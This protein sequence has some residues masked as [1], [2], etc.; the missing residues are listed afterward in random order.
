M[1]RPFVTFA[2][3]S[4]LA[5]SGAA[6]RTP[7]AGA[8]RNGAITGHVDLR[9]P[10]IAPTRRPGVADLGTAPVQPMPERQMSVVYLETAPRGAFA[11]TISNK[12]PTVRVADDGHTIVNGTR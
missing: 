2:L 8:A 9:R 5:L 1:R 11:G 4:A 3:A 6:A 12:A 10:T 7:F